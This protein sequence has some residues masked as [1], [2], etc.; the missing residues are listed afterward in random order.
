MTPAQKWESW[1]LGHP[2]DLGNVIANFMLVALWREY[3]DMDF[4]EMVN[5]V[6]KHCDRKGLN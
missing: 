5:E 4:E 1:G 2:Y 3:S 6:L